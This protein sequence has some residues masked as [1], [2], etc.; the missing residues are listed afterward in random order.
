[1]NTGRKDKRHHQCPSVSDRWLVPIVFMTLCAG[2]GGCQAKEVG[3]GHGVRYVHVSAERPR[4]KRYPIEFLRVSQDD[5]V[6]VRFNGTELT[7]EP[8]GTL[9]SSDAADSGIYVS[10]TDFRRQRA[11]LR[12]PAV[13]QIK[14]WY[15][16][17]STTP[18]PF[19]RDWSE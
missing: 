9:V 19:L 2:A 1:M 6:A 15:I 13:F 12:V 10:G 11:V 7:G 16:V 14:R 18:V 3:V 8:C 4:D 17:A 5:S